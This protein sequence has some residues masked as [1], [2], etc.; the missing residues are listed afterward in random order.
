M[1]FLI[2]LPIGLAVVIAAITF[3]PAGRPAPGVRLDLL[4]AVLASC[5]S[6]LLVFPLVQGRE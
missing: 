5:G 1:I 4:G 2:N 3:L 6:L